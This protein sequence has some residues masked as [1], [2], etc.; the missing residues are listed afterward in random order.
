MEEYVPCRKISVY[1][2]KNDPENI[3]NGEPEYLGLNFIVRRIEATEME[4]F[5]IE[6]LD[7]LDIPY[8]GV[9][10]YA[11][12]DFPVTWIWSKERII[13]AMKKHKALTIASQK[14]SGQ[15]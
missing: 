1:C 3:Q 8:D 5:V 7:V 2:I 9:N 14:C 4:R 10:V 15:K 11:S 13:E 6:T 12:V